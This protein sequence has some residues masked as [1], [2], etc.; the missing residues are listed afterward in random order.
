MKLF[1]PILLLTFFVQIVQ[2]KAITF[3]EYFGFEAEAR[4]VY[5]LGVLDAESTKY[6]NPDYE[7]CLADWGVV[8]AHN[9]LVDHIDNF[10]EFNLHQGVANYVI[11]FG[12]INCAETLTRK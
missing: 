2:A 8:G 3:E 10:K 9:A 5:L 11:I 4:G 1:V 7:R 6:S 12:M